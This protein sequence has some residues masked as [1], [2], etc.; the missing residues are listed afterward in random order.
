[1]QFP[2]NLVTVFANKTFG[3]YEAYNRNGYDELM[4]TLNIKTSSARTLEFPL[5]IVV[6]KPEKSGWEVVMICKPEESDMVKR[7]GVQWGSFASLFKFMKDDKNI[8]IY[9]D[10]LDGEFI[11]MDANGPVNYHPSDFLIKMN[12]AYI[13]RKASILDER[14]SHSKRARLRQTISQVLHG[15]R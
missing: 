10:L 7:Y 5:H 1:M 2:D 14:D 8:P 4:N 11:E 15:K 6:N 13:L 12:I 3:H 9:N